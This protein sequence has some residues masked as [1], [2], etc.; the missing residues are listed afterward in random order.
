VVEKRAFDLWPLV[1]A[2][3]EEMQPVADAAGT[4]I[5]NEVP[6]E[7][8][9]FADAALL[10][11]ILQNLVANAIRHTQRGEVVVGACEQQ[12][13]HAVECRVSDNGAGIPRELL[14]RIFEAGETT[15]SEA[16]GTGL[17]LAI[18]QT[19]TEA[20]G[21]KVTVES[22]E[23]AGSTFRFTLPMPARA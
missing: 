19:L 9:V 4:R 7:L 2:L 18:V 16:G 21:G 17:G 11:R 8:V 14:G 12:A 6:D 1:E 22:R 13:D 10:K 23:G 15:S 5:L 3:I 20:H